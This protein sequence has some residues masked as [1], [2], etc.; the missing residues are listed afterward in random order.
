[1]Q[2]PVI[3][4]YSCVTSAF[5]SIIIESIDKSFCIYAYPLIFFLQV[6]GPYI[7]QPPMMINDRSIAESS[8]V[9]TRVSYSR[10]T[11]SPA[12]ARKQDLNTKRHGMDIGMGYLFLQIRYYTDQLTDFLNF[13]LFYK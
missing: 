1:M 3:F 4:F 12:N 9:P 13:V 5:A 7:R 6:S 11:I 2:L 10:G 8:L